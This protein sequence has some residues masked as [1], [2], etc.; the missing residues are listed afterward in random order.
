MLYKNI[1]EVFDPRI[2]KPNENFARVIY[3]KQKF[4]ALD[5]Y[6]FRTK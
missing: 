5:I 2:I 6:Y 1:Q 4:L 3:S